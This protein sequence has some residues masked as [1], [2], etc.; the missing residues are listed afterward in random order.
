[1]TPSHHDYM[2]REKAKTELKRKEVAASKAR[3]S[4]QT[5][6]KQLCR[7]FA[8]PLGVLIPSIDVTAAL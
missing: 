8:L 2:M 4:E 5:S 3:A 6:P 1:M 7:Y